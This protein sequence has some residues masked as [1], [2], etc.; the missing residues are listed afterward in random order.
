MKVE[1]IEATWKE[2][3]ELVS[4]TELRDRWRENSS[5]LEEFIAHGVLE[6]AD[7]P[8]GGGFELE[9]V[10]LVRTACRLQEELDLDAHAV[11]VVLGLLQQV[12]DLEDEVTALRAQ[13]GVSPPGRP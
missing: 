8:D 13:L 2:G 9:T 3:H 10:T 1:R 4:I 12:R 5:Q 6:P 7:A 11:G